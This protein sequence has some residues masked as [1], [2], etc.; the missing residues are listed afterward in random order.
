MSMLELVFELWGVFITIFLLFARMRWL[1]EVWFEARIDW[2]LSPFDW[3]PTA[4][5]CPNELLKGFG[6]KRAL[7][8][9]GGHVALD[10]KCVIWGV[11][12]R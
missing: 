2:R 3:R 1:N 12:S 4:W 11:C 10:L 6:V 5:V 8:L 9:S 7:G